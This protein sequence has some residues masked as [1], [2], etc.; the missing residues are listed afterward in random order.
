MSFSKAQILTLCGTLARDL[1]ASD[2][3]DDF[4]DDVIYSLFDYSPPIFLEDE[5]VSLTDGTATY[6]FETNMLRLLYAI[7][8]DASLL[9]TDDNSLQGYSNE[10]RAAEGTPVAISIDD[11]QHQ[12]TLYPTPDFD[13]GVLVPAHGEPLGEDYPDDQLY[14]LFKE[15]RNSSIQDYYALPIALSTLSR[16]FTFSSLHVDVEFASLCDT[17]F[18][19]MIKLLGH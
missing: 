17:L 16:E 4:F 8:E 9:M 6:D 10:W 13:S 5:L 7:M 18:Q 15:Y 12:Y 19:V 14:I 1:E 3:I 11:L 2:T